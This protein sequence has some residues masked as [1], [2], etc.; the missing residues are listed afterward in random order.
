MAKKRKSE[1]TATRD[2]KACPAHPGKK[3]A[4]DLK[5]VGRS[6]TDISALLG[7]TR[8]HLNDIIAGRRN[9]TANIAVRVGKLLGGCAEV[10]MHQQ[11]AFDLWQAAQKIDLSKIPTLKT[12]AVESVDS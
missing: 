10:W 8:V 6:K 7:V 11:L 12:K 1:P 2:R 3:L 9:M 4:V 5:T